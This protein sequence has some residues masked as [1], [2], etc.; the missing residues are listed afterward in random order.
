MNSSGPDFLGIG[1][2]RAGTSWVFAQLAAH[3]DIWVPP[4]KE[5][6]FF[7][8]IDPQAR[9]LKHRYRYHL[10]SRIKQKA[11]PFLRARYAHR[12]EFFKNSYLEYLQ[13][14]WRFFTGRFDVDWYKS[15]FDP[16]FTSGRV[17]GEI[18]PAYSNLTPDTIGMILAMNPQ[19]K[20]ILIV[21]DP[22]E[23]L[24][25]GV[26]HYFR[27]VRGRDFADVTQTEI[28]A[29]LD[30]SKAVLRSR[31][32]EIVRV[33]RDEVGAARFFVQ[34]YERIASDPVGLIGELYGFLG[35]DDRF[36]PP[37][38]LWREKVNAYS[39]VHAEVPDY[40]RQYCQGRL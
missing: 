35:V 14:D 3:P 21:R 8:V 5:L 27:H 22:V 40:I 23:R 19:M 10:P 29:Y 38:F 37:A 18:T 11:A 32:D 6:H 1:M 30:G 39:G 16:C 15:L 13:W 20:F 28:L 36:L 34:P 7:D 24:W 4:L 12:P 25:S 9:Y 2:E 33:W 26:V 17:A 31:S